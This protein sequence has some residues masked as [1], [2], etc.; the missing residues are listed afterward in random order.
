[1]NPSDPT[2]ILCAACGASAPEAPRCAA[3]GE[4]PRLDGRYRLLRIVGHGAVGTTYRAVDDVEGEAVAI[5]EMPLR[6]TTPRDQVERIE[7][8][9]RVLGEI[10]HDRIPTLHAH[11]T[12]GAGKHRAFYLVQQFVEGRTL[13]DEMAGKRYTEDEVLGVLD[14]IC[15]V[16]EYLHGLAPP[17]IHRDLKPKNLMR[18]AGDGQ[19]VLIDFGAVRDV[20]QDPSTGGSTVAGTYGYM[21]P[22]QFRGEATPRS[23]LYAVGAI[24]VELLSRRA[25]ID[26]VGVDHQLD[27]EKVVHASE[28]TKGLIRRLLSASPEM[29]PASAKRVREEIAR[30]RGGEAV[31][32]APEPPRRVTLPAPRATAGAPRR[33]VPVTRELR[34]KM[35][36]R[37]RTLAVALAFL[38]GPLGLHHWYLGRYKWGIVSAILTFTG[39]LTVLPLIVSWVGGIKMLRQTDDAFDARYN[40]ALLEMARG[41]TLGVAEQIREL[42]HLVEAGALTE[43]EFRHEKARLLGQRAPGT[44]AQLGRDLVESV[45]EQF[46]HNLD[47]L[48]AEVADQL[49][50]HRKKLEA[51]GILQRRYKGVEVRTFSTSVGPPDRLDRVRDTGRK[52]QDGRKGK[53]GRDRYLNRG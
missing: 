39:F 7:R 12:A 15:E 14:E 25:L 24:A 26:L 8:E 4:D 17:V 18:R 10:R 5:K 19:L 36:A 28:P 50:K 35:G 32:P 1:M 34:K 43:E 44:L 40:P 13:A 3:C 20:V 23:D 31:E 16:L 45:F 37:D 27:W 49:G 38:G 2:D 29:R 30:I 47:A 46:E 53:K 42:H 6:P 9:A 33:P 41:D 52:G 51:K 48:P 22:E 21:A 11:F